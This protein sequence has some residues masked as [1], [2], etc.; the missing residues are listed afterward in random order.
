MLQ[1]ICTFKFLLKKL[2]RKEMH[3]KKIVKFAENWPIMHFVEVNTR[4]LKKL[5][6]NAKICIFSQNIMPN[7]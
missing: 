5:V 4:M 2:L 3:C 1:N 6:M 7:M